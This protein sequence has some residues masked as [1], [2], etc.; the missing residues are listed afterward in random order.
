VYIDAHCYYDNSYDNNPPAKSGQNKCSPKKINLSK[1]NFVS[2]EKEEV[3]DYSITL[4]NWVK[5]R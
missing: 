3:F 5:K 4:E 2:D 1:L